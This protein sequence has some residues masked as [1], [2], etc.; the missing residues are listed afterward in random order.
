MKSESPESPSRTDRSILVATSISIV[1]AVFCLFFVMGFVSAWLKGEGELLMR[2]L[3]FGV[4]G[5]VGV[6]CTGLSAKA[7]ARLAVPAW[8]P[9]IMSFGVGFFVMNG[10]GELL[11]GR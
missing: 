7:W 10:L 3:K 9:L 4:C 2:G 8:L 1:I 5:S 6:L 11:D